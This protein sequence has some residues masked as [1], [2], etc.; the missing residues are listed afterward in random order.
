[1]DEK[2]ITHVAEENVPITVV[3]LRTTFGKFQTNLFENTFSNEI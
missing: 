1:M 3:Q 2:E